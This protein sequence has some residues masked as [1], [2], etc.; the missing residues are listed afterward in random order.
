MRRDPHSYA[1][2]AEVRVTH[3]SLDLTVDFTGRRL[4]GRATLHLEVAPEATEVVLDTRDLIIHAVVDGGGN[5]LSWEL[6]GEDSILGRPLA[7]RL[8]AGVTSITVSYETGPGASALQWLAPA[9]T[10]GGTHPFLF[11]QGHAILTRTW[12]PT[13]DS[14]G[15]RQTYDARI[16]VPAALVAVMSAERLTPEGLVVSDGRRFDFRMSEPVPPYLI[17]LAVGG[18]SFRE[19]GPRTGVFAEPS[20]VD[21]AQWEFAELERM[22]DAAES[23]G[24]PYRWGRFDV[25]V[26]PPSFPYGGMENPRVAFL[27]PTLLAGD[28][29]LT[30]VAAHELA[31]AWAGN[32]VTHASWSDFWLNEGFT[33]YMELRINEALYGLERATML[34]VH[35]RRELD[36][37]MQL[38]GVDSADTRLCVDLDGRDPAAGVTVVPYVKGAT[39]LR[40]IEQAVGRARFDEWL[41]WWFDRHA[42]RA[43][44]TQTFVD[45]LRSGLLEENPTGESSIDVEGWIH[46]TGM[47]ENVPQP[48]SERLLVVERAAA[49]FVAGVPA[50][51]LGVDGWSPQEW[52]HFLSALPRVLDADRMRDLDETFALSGSRNA[53]IL[54]AWLKL[55]V[56][57]R[58]DPSRVALERFLTEQGRG[59]FLRPLYTELMSSEWGRDL[60]RSVYRRARPTY[61]ATV[62]RVLDSIVAE[63]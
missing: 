8:S 35:G 34:E 39:F 62:T 54:F 13:Q 12:L 21:S 36:A 61:H 1:R 25:L 32:L 56:S 38:L 23:I 11:T 58:Y 29:S 45:D 9:Q 63:V 15:V 49:A 14:P 57:A 18:L 50:V 60:A 2:P 30:T 3:I 26:L 47:P 43:V 40:V 5:A 59:K 44:T 53:E 42:F 17:A 31:H 6:G 55:V 46:G 33:V 48:V 24:G 20:V 22:I 51:S 16:T 10:A 37:E 52:R 4:V 19:V 7:V 27:T 41:R 28:R